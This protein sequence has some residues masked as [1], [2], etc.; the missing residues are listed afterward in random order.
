M[1]KN[2]KGLYRKVFTY[3]GVQCDISAK[4]EENLY[5]KIAKKKLEIDSGNFVINSS[6]TVSRWCDEW[7]EVYK[8]P[9]V[10]KTY[11]VDLELTVRLHIKPEIG[12]MK[13]ADVKK[14]HLQKLLNNH[15]G[16][17][18]SHVAKIRSCLYEIFDDAINEEIISK[19]PAHK[20]MLPSNKKGTRIPFLPK[21]YEAC[22]EVAKTHRA[23][24]WVL[25]ML[26]G[27]LR[28]QETVPLMWTDIDFKK[29][30]M[31]IDKAAEFSGNSGT[32]KE[33]KTQ[34]GKRIAGISDE[35]YNLLIAL[36][37]TSIYVFP[38]SD[39]GMM[40][41]TTM[42]RMWNSFMRSLDI[43]MGAKLYRNA[44]V[45]SKLQQGLSPYSCRH[46]C[47]TN[48]VLSGADPK[49]VQVFAGHESV[50]T[51]LK[52]YTHLDK[53]QAAARVLQF[54][55]GNIHGSKTANA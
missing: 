39:G 37:K 49:T 13:I 5:L 11:Y 42:K 53:E 55:N 33:T 41:K 18:Y 35:L 38:K 23:G 19:N 25:S 9:N 22:F 1:K 46:T 50:E 3:N 27:A 47:I 51:T 45:E 31:T 16:K 21:E 12:N 24:A 10:G 6:T 4:S 40:T 8:R 54:Q 36:P 14:I 29:R 2:S 7:L 43:Y 28:P 52:Y 17:S 34:A 44:I 26:T 48:L 32:I 20:L 30:T 15:E